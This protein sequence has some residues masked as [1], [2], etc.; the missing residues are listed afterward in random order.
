MSFGQWVLVIT[1]GIVGVAGLALLASARRA[2]KRNATDG[3]GIPPIMSVLTGFWC[4]PWAYQLIA[5][6]MIGTG[7]FPLIPSR[8]LIAATVLLIAGWAATTWLERREE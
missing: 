6:G 3:S 4:L 1:G 5:F 2:A 8:F 7:R